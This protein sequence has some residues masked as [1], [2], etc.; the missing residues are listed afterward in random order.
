MSW[1][2]KSKETYPTKII[3]RWKDGTEWEQVVYP[4]E[5]EDPLMLAH[6]Q[7]YLGRWKAIRDGDEIRYG[8]VVS[9]RLKKED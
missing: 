3:V 1:F 6:E 9:I 2:W 5:N 4:F 8:T 7:A